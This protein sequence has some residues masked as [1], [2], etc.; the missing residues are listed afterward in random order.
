MNR[1]KA[2]A[3][4]GLGGLGAALGAGGLALAQYV[5]EQMTPAHSREMT[6]QDHARNNIGDSQQRMPGV[7]DMELA[8]YEGIRQGLMSGAITGSEVNTMAKQGKLPP[9][10]ISLLTDAHDWSSA[11]PYPFGSRSIPEVVGAADLR[12]G[13]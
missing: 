11:E 8:L 1:R 6:Q 2:G 13:A 10:V 12:G 5:G 7:T 9:N 3:A 4:L